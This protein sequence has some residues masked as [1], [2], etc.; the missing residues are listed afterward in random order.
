MALTGMLSGV[1]GTRHDRERK[2]VQ[3]IVDEINEH[4][5]RLQTVSEEELSGQ[6]EK[7]R[8]RITEVTSGLEARIAELR[9]KKRQTSDPAARDVIDTELSGVDGRGGVEQELRKA[10][11]EVLEELLPEAF[12]T[13]REAARRLLGSKVMV[14]GQE[15]DWNMV[16]Y[17]V[18][19][20]GGIQLHLGRIAEMATGE[21]KTLVVTLPLYLN[22]L[23]GKG[24]H[25]ITVNSYIARRVSELM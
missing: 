24:E 7:L 14:T 16:P 5:A 18:Q 23:P 25:L 3:P 15:M 13:A 10:T 2:R 17:D 11:A 19:L 1:F 4:Y 9:E 8:A 20:M 6:T 12:A 22:A 21:G